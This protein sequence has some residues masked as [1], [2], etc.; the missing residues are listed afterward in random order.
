ML[1]TNYEA[2]MFVLKNYDPH[3]HPAHFR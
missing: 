3:H 2:V 1:A